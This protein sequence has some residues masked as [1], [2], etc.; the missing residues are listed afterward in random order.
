MYASGV[1][2]SKHVNRLTYSLLR[3]AFNYRNRF[4][5]FLAGVTKNKVS[6]SPRAQRMIALVEWFWGHRLSALF[7]IAVSYSK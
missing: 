7:T 3:P 2:G 4:E 5:E 6:M 1:L